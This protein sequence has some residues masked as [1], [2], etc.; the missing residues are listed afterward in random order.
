MTIKGHTI[1]SKGNIKLADDCFIYSHTP[2]KGCGAGCKDCKYT[3]YAK[4]IYDFRK[5]VRNKWDTNLALSLTAKFHPMFCAELKARK[6]KKV[7]L[8]QAGDF[9]NNAVTNKFYKIIKDNPDVVFYGYTK[10]KKAFDKLNELP[11]CNIMYSYINGYLN[12]GS[13]EYCK[14]LAQKFGCHICMLDE[15]AG[16]KCTRDCTYCLDKKSAAR[17][18]CFV[19]HGTHKG[20]LS[21]EQS[22]MDKLKALPD[23]QVPVHLDK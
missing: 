3:C 10:N 15:A 4:A 1:L 20:D 16:E 22:V 7:R 19:I 13:E 21:Y 14:L 18:V 23:Y 6:V 2:I 5:S 17:G 8:M 9:Y 12:Y 11:N